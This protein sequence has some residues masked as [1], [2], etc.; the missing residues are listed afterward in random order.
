MCRRSTSATPNYFVKG[1]PYPDGFK[2]AI[3]P[4]PSQQ[5]A[6]FTAG[7]LDEI[8]AT[9]T[10]QFTAFDVDP[11]QKQNPKAATVRSNYGIPNAILFQLGDSKSP[12]L[13]IRVRQAFSM[14]I[15][16]D[17]IGR[18]VRGGQSEQVVHV[19]AYM[20]KWS[21]KIQDLDQSTQAFYKYDP[22]E[23]KKLLEAA[24][25]TDLQL[26]LTWANSFGTP[27]FTKQAET[28]GN[29]LGAVGIKSTLFVVVDFNKDYIS[30]ACKG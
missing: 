9:I 3:V 17:V 18:T 16:R 5:L 6:Q 15:D 12:F 1:Q 4:D 29:F 14:A 11:V 10:Q 26:K 7:N 30:G 23:S 19:P 8:G 13:D 24:G 25:A 20:G 28:I 27:P 22:G 21:L 2:I